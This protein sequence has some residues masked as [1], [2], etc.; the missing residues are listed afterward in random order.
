MKYKNKYNTPEYRKKYTGLYGTWYAL[1]QRCNNPNNSQY[2]DYGGR[3]ITYPSEWDSFETF[4]E[5]MGMGY[6]RGFD[7]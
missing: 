4:K 3:G 1:R 2:A 6:K 7:H 5:Q